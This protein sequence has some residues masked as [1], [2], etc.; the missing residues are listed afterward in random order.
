MN[1]PLNQC[2]NGCGVPPCPPSL[3]ICRAC[4]DKVTTNLE[5]MI[6]RM[7][8]PPQFIDVPHMCY[9]CSGTGEDHGGEPF[10]PI[11][12]GSGETTVRYYDEED[13]VTE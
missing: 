8:N 11:C 4:Q 2:A 5:Q 12:G 3:V 7:E 13:R 9:Y 10:C 6:K 1:K